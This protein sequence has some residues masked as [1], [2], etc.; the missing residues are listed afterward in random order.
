[1]FSLQIV[2]ELLRT[3]VGDYSDTPMGPS[4]GELISYYY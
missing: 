4:K 3:Q 2:E 1:M